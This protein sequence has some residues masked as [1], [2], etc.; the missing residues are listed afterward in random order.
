MVDDAEAD[1][2]R[3][4][5]L[6]VTPIAFQ[7]VTADGR[8]NGEGVRHPA[9][10]FDLVHEFFRHAEVLQTAGG[11]DHATGIFEPYRSR[12][13]I[14][15]RPTGLFDEQT[16]GLVEHSLTEY[17]RQN[18]ALFDMRAGG[19]IP[20]RDDIPVEFR[21]NHGNATLVDRNDAWRLDGAGN[22]LPAECNGFHT[23]A[24]D[25]AGRDLD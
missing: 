7:H 1:V 17:R 21:R 3:L 2:T 13:F 5:A 18:I 20:H 22:G 6:A 9:R 25:L 24:L 4:E 11:A 19:D 16:C 12:G 10:A 14:V 15:A 8:A 23:G